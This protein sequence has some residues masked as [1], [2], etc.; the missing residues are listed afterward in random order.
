MTGASDSTIRAMVKN[1]MLAQWE[2]Q[3]FRLPEQPELPERKEFVLSQA[4]QTVYNRMEPLL[5][6]NS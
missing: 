2:E 4:Q 1:G 5:L 6:S 3:T